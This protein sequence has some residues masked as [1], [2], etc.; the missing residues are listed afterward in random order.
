MSVTC[1]NPDDLE[2]LKEEIQDIPQALEKI[3][4]KELASLR[5]EILEK[6]RI[7]KESLCMNRTGELQMCAGNACLEIL[8]E[9]TGRPSGYY[10][11][12]ACSNCEPFQAFCDFDLNLMGTKGWMRVADLDTTDP[13]QQCP[14]Q[15]KL[16]TSPRR[17]CGRSTNRPGCDSTIF[18]THG[19]QYDKVAG[20][21]VGYGYGSPDGMQAS[22]CSS[23]N[24]NKPYV[25]GISITHGYPRNHIWT[26]SAGNDLSECPC[27][28]GNTQYQPSYV[29]S[30]YYC[31]IGPESEPLWDGED[32]SD[33]EFPCC[34]RIREHSGWFIKGL[35]TPTTND[36]EVRNC[37]DESLSNEDVRVEHIAIYVQ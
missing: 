1:S 34:Q 30:D 6:D 27:V 24:I 9:K 18:E 4:P 25:D 7:I 20:W 14:S 37:A 3:I 12:K 16:V 31:E 33:G 11:L 10:W 21:M 17:V 35:T 32:C 15:F 8:E 2:Q 26:Y 19:I 28:I 36:I 23:C 13:N 5:A 29:G 22:L